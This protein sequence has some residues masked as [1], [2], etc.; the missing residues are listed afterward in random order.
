M[1]PAAISLMSRYST[2]PFVEYGLS[3]EGMNHPHN[4]WATRLD[5]LSIARIATDAQRPD[6]SA[7][8]GLGSNAKGRR[9]ITRRRMGSRSV[10]HAE[11]A[12]R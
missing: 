4:R 2:Y 7:P 8:A 9:V 1:F 6:P 3:S 5:W 12:R 10:C 11:P